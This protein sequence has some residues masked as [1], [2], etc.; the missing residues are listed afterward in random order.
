MTLQLADAIARVRE[1]L[2]DEA[3]SAD[4]ILKFETDGGIIGSLQKASDYISSIRPNILSSLLPIYAAPDDDY[5]VDAEDIS[6]WTNGTAATLTSTV[7]FFPARNVKITITDANYSITAFTLTVVGKDIR[8]TAQTEI[9]YWA[10]GLVQEG[11]KLFSSIT[12]VTGTAITGNGAGDVL[13]VGFGKRC[14]NALS[15]PSSGLTTCL[16][17]SACRDIYG[18]P[19][20][21]D[22][23][24]FYRAD[25]PV[26]AGSVS[27]HNV[28]QRGD[29]LELLYDS[30]LT[31]GQQIRIEWGKKHTLN[32]DSVTI[33]ESFKELLIEGAT[34]YAL[35]MLGDKNIN[36]ITDGISVGAQWLGSGM[37][38]IQ[39]FKTGVRARVPTGARESYSRS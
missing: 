23:I 24:E 36:V 30:T 6:A 22:V 34:G 25:Y 28:I 12:S 8:G 4:V 35:R 39:L 5:I 37:T 11:E 18:R 9:F 21:D 33:P 19:Y 31:A 17:I 3:V 1:D 15:L 38:K 7:T 27:W 14:Y 26:L 10:G 32:M 16:D 13:D 2:M 20:F 29:E